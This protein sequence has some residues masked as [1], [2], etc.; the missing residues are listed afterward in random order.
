MTITLPAAAD[1]L[2]IGGSNQTSGVLA[3]TSGNTGNWGTNQ[4][5]T[6][7]L[8]ADP[9]AGK[10]VV[11]DFTRLSVSD[12]E[13][14]PRYLTFTGGSSGN[15][16]TAQTINVK[17]LAE[18]TA[19]TTR[20]SITKNSSN[21][22]TGYKVDLNVYRLAFDLSATTI[23]IDA[24]DTTGTVTL[25]A[26]ND[27]NDLANQRLTLAQLAHPTG[28]KWIAKG[29]TD[30]TLTINDDDELGQVTGVAAVQKTDAV[31]NPA[32]GATVSWTKV[33][34]ATG[35]VIEWKTGTQ[36]Y[37]S[38]RRLVAGDVA[39]YDIPG[40]NLTPGTTYDIRVYATKSGSDHG[41][42]SDKVS[43]TYK[44]HPRLHPRRHRRPHRRRAGNR[45]RHR[46]LHRQA[47]LQPSAS[48]TLNLSRA[49]GS[50]T[51]TPINPTFSPLPSHS[52]PRTGT[53]PRPSPSPS[54]RTP[55]AWTTR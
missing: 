35:Y 8:A 46:N 40:T 36:I 4:S 37:D 10:T 6:V 33:D 49:T 26:Q 2:T 20:V 27:Y 31:G 54:R 17:F 12:P 1:K 7:K 38:T 11:V 25:T 48:V 41:L 21:V 16:N 14:T 42:P 52:P 44:G 39:S 55:T 30:P 43:E 9:G 15:Y 5:A 29:T 18:P 22:T 24:G 51:T 28:T 53:P 47:L 13:V 3:F 34:D 19:A 23:T 32:A 45:L 50:S